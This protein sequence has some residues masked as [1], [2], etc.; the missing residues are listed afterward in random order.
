MVLDLNVAER[1]SLG[2]DVRN[3]SVMR[4]VL[5]HHRLPIATGQ[6][7]RVAC[8]PCSTYVAPGT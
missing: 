4:S 6:S 2:Y 5:G 1:K 3:E 7:D 8:L